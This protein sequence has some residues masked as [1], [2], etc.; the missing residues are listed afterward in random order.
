MKMKVILFIILLITLNIITT[1][2]TNVNNNDIIKKKPT[3]SSTKNSFLGKIKHVIVLMLENRSFDHFFGFS[4]PD[5]NVN[6][7]TGKEYNLENVKD[8]NSKKVFVSK[9]AP[10]INE[11]DPD[12]STPA[13]KEKVKDGMSGFVSYENN[14]GHK[15]KNFCDVMRTFTPEKLPILTTLAKEYAI[16]DE[17]FCSH[18]GPTWPN[19]M[20]CLSGTS[21]GSTLTGTWYHN[22]VGSLF[23][24]RT[25]FD[26]VSEAGLKWR[27]YY[28][29]TP[30]E[31]FMES[32][33]HSPSNVKNLEA[34]YDD[35][36]NG[37][38]PNYAWINPR[39][40]VNMTTGLGSQD[41]HPDHDVAL[42]ER[43]IKEIYEALRASPQFNETLFI[44]TYDEHGGFY[45]H[46]E[47]PTNI[48]SPGDGESSYPDTGYDFTKLG[49][50][51][52]T[53]LVS[54]YIKKGTI[55]SEPPAK[56]KPFENSKYD[57][58]SIM[59]TA[60]K[61]LE[62]PLQNL[63][64]RDGWSAT[65]EHVF[66]ELDVPRSDCPLHLPAPPPLS[67]NHMDEGNLPLNDLQKDIAHVHTHVAGTST[68]LTDDKLNG[69]KQ[70]DISK[71][72]Q[73]VYKQHEIQTLSW[74][75]S[76]ETASFKLVCQPASDTTF[77]EKSF[78]VN[79]NSSY[80][81]NTISTMS[82]KNDKQIPYCLDSGIT[83][84]TDISISL[85]YPSQHV[86]VNRDPDQHWIVRTDATIV[87]KQNESLCVTNLDPN[88]EGGGNQL[89]LDVCDGR[90]EQHYSY[91][92]TPR[93]GIV[94][95]EF[96]YGDDT[97]IIG[98]VV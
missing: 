39:S 96:Y 54:P 7:L 15:N 18:P 62:M 64:G 20:F 98:V 22:K 1:T 34:F 80:K 41:Q 36:K 97:N 78:I 47:P 66:E 16:M 92:T 58:T 51:V 53:I 8:K 83:K 55:I 2:S 11:C 12:H 88:I 85:C 75:K 35:A 59:S 38:L 13:T 17:F 57:L 69:L 79:S 67:L 37:N 4:K 29:D 49:V 40:G 63:T 84:G 3:S 33:A 89:I 10:Y 44:I 91:H 61:L 46:V 95:G 42:G 27:N 70:R 32:I 19:R 45:D 87:S 21:A 73:E 24:Q 65:F 6:G 71:L 5:L 9:D 93:D 23:P 25:I 31:L 48:S 60:R 28:N 30:W 77:V 94:P 81:Y 43:Y 72:L 90:V 52:P 86:N 82:L 68:I 26:Q 76:K 56:Q 74:Q 50:R 14:K